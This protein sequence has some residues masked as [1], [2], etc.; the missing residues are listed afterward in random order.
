[1]SGWREYDGSLIRS[2]RQ[3]SGSGIFVKGVQV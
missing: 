3:A 1:M 2:I